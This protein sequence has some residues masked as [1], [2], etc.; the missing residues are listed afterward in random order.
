LFA[1]GLNPFDWSFIAKIT[2]P[3]NMAVRG[4]L[5][6]MV[7]GLI[8]LVVLYLTNPRRVSEMAR[9]HLDDE[10]LTPMVTQ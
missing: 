2:Y 4:C 9:V 7:L 1:T 8:Y 10:E 5:I 6:W 3:F